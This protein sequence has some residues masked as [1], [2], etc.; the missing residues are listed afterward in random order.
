[1]KLYGLQILLIILVPTAL[2]ARHRHQRL[3]PRIIASCIRDVEYLQQY[4]IHVQQNLSVRPASDASVLACYKSLA[5]NPTSYKQEIVDQFRAKG[6]GWIGIPITEGEMNI[7]EEISHI[8]PV[9]ISPKAALPILTDKRKFKQFVSDVGYAEFVPMRYDSIPSVQYP[10]VVKVHPQYAAGGHGVSIAADENELRALIGNVLITD[11]LV[12]EFISS[13]LEVSVTVVGLRGEVISLE[14]CTWME[15]EHAKYIIVGDSM[16]NRSFVKCSEIPRWDKLKEI[17]TKI[18]QGMK[19]TGFGFIQIKYDSLNEPKLIE[20]NGRI[21][22][23][24][25]M[26]HPG[27]FALLVKMY[28]KAWSQ[29]KKNG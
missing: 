7:W 20:M 19:F 22:G 23:T 12:E 3:Q 17:S 13:T 26:Y 25:R 9:A 28:Y 4:G 11:V 16:Y 5:S 2:G 14:E 10:C 1:M 18:V 27:L 8:Y 24:V 6:S 29:S 15:T 21:D